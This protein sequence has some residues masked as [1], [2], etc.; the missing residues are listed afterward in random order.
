MVSGSEYLITRVGMENQRV[1][2]ENLLVTY[3]S[4]H[5]VSVSTVLKDSPTKSISDNENDVWSSDRACQS[6]R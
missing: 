5:L 6:P 1:R 3:T 4:Y 2:L